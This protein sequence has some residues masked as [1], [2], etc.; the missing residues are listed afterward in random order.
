MEGFEPGC[1]NDIS[2]HSANWA[3]TIDQYR[4]QIDLAM[5]EPWSSGND[6]R[7]ILGSN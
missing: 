1:S 4:L 5:Q 2:D 6:R 3:P 7:L